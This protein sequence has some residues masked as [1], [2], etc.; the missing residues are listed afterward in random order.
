VATIRVWTNPNH[1]LRCLVGDNYFPIDNDDAWQCLPHRAAAIAAGF[2]MHS[3]NFYKLIPPQ[4]FALGE[5]SL[6]VCW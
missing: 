2:V 3:Y 4:G 1:L 6:Q 5:K